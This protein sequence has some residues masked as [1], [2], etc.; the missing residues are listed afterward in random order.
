MSR[1]TLVLVLIGLVPIAV[2]LC[3]YLHESEEEAIE[4]VAEICRQ[5]L[6]DGDAD[7][8]VA[9]LTEDAE[10]AGLMGSGLLASGL[11]RRVDQASGRLR[12]LDLSLRD[13]VVDGENARGVWLVKGLLRSSEDWGDRVVVVARV[14]FRQSPAGWLVRRVEIASP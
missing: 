3:A 14:D 1:R 6:L 7:R 12:K 13:M 5:A 10:V 2:G 8:I 11:S 4:R 9:H